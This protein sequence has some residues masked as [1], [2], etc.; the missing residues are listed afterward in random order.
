MCGITG[1][2]ANAPRDPSL[3]E[4]AVKCLRHRGPDAAGIFLSEN[5]RTGLGHTRLSIIDLSEAGRQ[6]MGLVGTG[7]T[8]SFNGEIYNYRELRAELSA[9][10]AKFVSQTDTEVLL[11]GYRVWGEGLLPRLSGIFAFAIHDAAR[12]ELLIVRDHLGVKPI[13]LAERGRRIS[14]ASEIKALIQLEPDL[15]G[16]DPLALARYATFLWCPGERTPFKGVR[17]LAPGS[18]LIVKNGQIVREWRYWDLPRYGPADFADMRTCAA[19]LAERLDIVVERQ[20]VADAPLGAFLS[21]GVDSTAV[22]AAA[23]RINP[24]LTCYTIRAV[25]GADSGVTDDLP[26]ARQAAQALGVRLREVE[27]DAG[28]MAD[29]LALMVGLLD[30]PLADPACLNVLYISRAARADGFKVLLSGTG[31]DDVFSGYRRHAALAWAERLS[32]LPSSGFR[33]AAA[34]LGPLS[35]QGAARRGGRLMQ[36]LA[37]RPGDR[38]VESFRWLDAQRLRSVLHPDIRETL[39]PREEE[40]PI[41]AVLDGSEGLPELERCL[42]LEKRFFLADH[43][44]IYT[45]KMAMAAGIEVRVPLIDRELVEF[46]ARI[47]ADWKTYGADPKHLFKLSQRGR[48]PDAT[49]DR[50]KAGFGAPLRRWL[51]NE[52]RPMIDDLL[53]EEAIARRGMFDAAGVATLRRQDE[54]GQVD[55]A[56]PIFALACIEQWCRHFVDQPPARQCALFDPITHAA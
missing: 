26:Y 51:R 6:P 23:R 22:V 48:I 10:G 36:L 7:L 43:N 27:V 34:A 13:Y 24:E 4:R 9:A 25:G 46:G 44:L 28:R 30:E 42:E 3:L 20:M 49:I 21:G 32:W 35:K 17:K 1:Y 41:R 39:Q 5:G 14:F 16:V 18:A 37:E 33:A 45:D 11:Q 15:G 55:A 38:L 53:S 12:D 19:E 2:S 31:G 56:Y 54:A 8:I 29:D 52:L 50:P 47:P 40:I